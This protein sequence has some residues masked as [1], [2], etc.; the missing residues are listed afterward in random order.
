[1]QTVQGIR[2]NHPAVVVKVQGEND[3]A[4]PQKPRISNNRPDMV[5]LSDE[6][7]VLTCQTTD[8]EYS[9]D[10]FRLYNNGYLV[11]EELSYRNSATFTIS[12]GG[13]A[14]SD[15]YCDYTRKLS[16][17]SISS[18]ESDRIKITVVAR[19][20]KPQIS[21]NRADKVYLSDE[22]VVL[23]C[24]TT[25]QEYSSDTF[26][27]YNDGHLV[28]EELSYQNSATFTITNGGIAPR[29]YYCDYARTVSGRSISSLESDRIKITVMARPQKPRISNNRPD[30]VYLSDESV[31]LTCQTTD[32]EYSGDTFRLYNGGYLVN[33]EL[34]YRNSATFTI[35]NGGVAPSDYYCDY[36]R[37]LSGRSISSP[38]SDRIKITVVARPQKP[39]IS[40][41]RPDMVYLSDESVVL[42]CQ[43]T[44]QEYSGDTFRLYNDGYLVN[45]ELS[46]R[47]SATFTISNGGV[48]PR[49]YYCDY[50]R[51]LSG[52]SI[53]SPESDRIKI[54]VVARP[55]KPQISSN[56]ADKVYLSDE[57]VV[58]TCQTTDQEYSSDTF[59][60]YNDG[61]LVNEELSYRNSAT[62]T[63][64]NGGIA[65]R[66]YYCDYTCTV[67]DRSISSP[68]SD[69]IKLT[70][71]DRPQKPQI[72]SNRPDKVY[73][74][75][76][77]VI[78]TCRKTDQEYYG[79]TFRLYNNGHLVKEK[80][81]L[82]NSAMFTIANGG[83]A[84][85]DYSCDYTRT[86]SGR[87]I[88]SPES[89]RIK[90]MVMARPQKPQISSNRADKVY[91]SDESVRLT[92]RKTDQEYYGD[93]FRLY[94]N[95]HLVKEKL[96]WRN[97]ATFTISN[98]RVAPWD[99]YCDYT[100]TVSSRRISSPESN[101]IK[102]TVMARPQK[103]QISSNRPDEVYVSDESVILT[104]QKT[105][106]EYSGD[107]F[108]LYNDG[109][110]V[111]EKLS[112]RNSATFTFTNGGVAPWDYSCDYTRTVSGRTIS[113]PESNRIKITVLDLPRPSISL[114]SGY[115]AQGKKV[116]FNC[117]S[118]KGISVGTFFLYKNGVRLNDSVLQS[119]DAQNK[120]ATFTIQNV[121]PGNS[122]NYT[123]GY[124]LL[125][126]NRYLTSAPSNP[127]LLSL[128]VKS[129]LPWIPVFPV[130][131]LILMLRVLGVY[132]WK[133]GQLRLLSSDRMTISYGKKE[134]FQAQGDDRTGSADLKL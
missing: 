72:S 24:Q 130:V 97:S 3:L 70:V 83:V 26:R 67:S 43:T 51:K 7:V 82:R 15:Y 1:M 129:I 11:N 52:R 42:T 23:T 134:S 126:G 13:V 107:T 78:L 120:S 128:N 63:I 47:N 32:Q 27:L 102:I 112:Q 35:S 100:R 88:S 108:R 14:P 36:T 49:D 73:V 46:Y 106:Q 133:K 118:T 132:C 116:T 48:A 84:P 127:V 92:C 121:D 71:M 58:L 30:M 93:T 20:Q 17:R 105:D 65:P 54:T 81:S 18:P 37:K 110:L 39:R 5:Y 77:S 44:D 76:E 104:C 99:Y 94:N 124:Q 21:S 117:T 87:S 89:N 64:T 109:L 40:N 25:D 4:R 115:D 29:D 122:G 75:D 113:S 101:R 79:D 91:V 114:A 95:G 45:E 28:N 74:S 111:K 8:Q 19:P 61:H 53:S 90:I 33:E 119:R 34:S 56:R 31:V 55:Q 125:D 6:S 60:L 59:R 9:G 62:F 131:T 80:L 69:R 41:N 85:W 2:G 16:G 22:P 50:T 68:E 98:G 10:T 123:C 66:D 103:P 12:N 38:E 57:S 86:V 96:L